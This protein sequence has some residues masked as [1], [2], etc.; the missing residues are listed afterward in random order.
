[1]DFDNSQKYTSIFDNYQKYS[2][3]E[4]FNMGV[5]GGSYY[6]PVYSQ[7]LK[8]ELKNDVPKY[9]RE[10]VSDTKIMM[11]DYDV[12]KN[13]Y[14]VKVGLSL[15]EWEEKGWIHPQDPRGWIEFKEIKSYLATN[16]KIYNSI[17]DLL[18]YFFELGYKILKTN[19]SFQFIISNKFAK[20]NSFHVFPGYIYC[21]LAYTNGC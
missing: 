12:S 16:F 13:Y 6:R 2:P 9:I 20:A 15:P 7:V 17:A 1:M 5:L 4:M 8:K 21:H 3:I 14:K 18:T 10:S 11:P 19:G